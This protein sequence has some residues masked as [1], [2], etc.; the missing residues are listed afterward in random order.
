MDVD[1]LR[2]A[3][4]ASIFKLLRGYWQLGEKLNAGLLETYIDAVEENS[5]EAVRLTCQRIASGQSGL[6][7]SFPPTPADIAERATLLDSATKPEPG[8]YNGLL[9]MDW[10]HGRVDLRGLT[11][12]EQDVIIKVH[13]VA[14]DGV[15]FALL[16]LEEKIAKVRDVPR[17]EAEKAGSAR[18]APPKPSRP[19][20]EQKPWLELDGWIEWSPEYG[21]F[22]PIDPSAKVWLKLDDSAEVCRPD[23]IV[24]REVAWGNLEGNQVSAYKVDRRVTP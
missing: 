3:K 15:N 11:E 17:L 18:V 10:G 14:P 19:P 9:E 13:G 22:P 8:K 24:A 6:N 23:S 12:R 7:S 2:D 5:V 1:M 16:T 4:E 21:A 20:L